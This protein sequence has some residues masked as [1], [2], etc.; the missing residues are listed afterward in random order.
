MTAKEY[1]SQAYRLNR[2]INTKL[3]EMAAVREITGMATAILSD[4]P[5][6]ATRNIRRI[7]DSIAKLMDMESELALD[8][9]RLVNIRQ[10]IAEVIE[11]IDNPIYSS[12]LS[13]RYLCF[14]EWDAIANE[15]QYDS[16]Y[17]FKL[18]GRALQKVD[19]QRH[20]KILE[21]PCGS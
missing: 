18:H 3:S 15:L 21:N 16:K 8:I 7:E 9:E 5:R 19:T 12:L 11:A 2:R 14:K 20:Q 10:E 4:M 6:S 17:I 1:L 13:L